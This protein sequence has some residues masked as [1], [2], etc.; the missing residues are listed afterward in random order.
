MQCIVVD[1]YRECM[2]NMYCIVWT[3]SMSICMCGRLPL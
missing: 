2:Y 1:M 3:A